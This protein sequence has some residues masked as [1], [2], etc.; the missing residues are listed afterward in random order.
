VPLIELRWRCARCGHQRIASTATLV[1]QDVVAT[2]VRTSR[3]PCR[4][5]IG[6]MHSA[7]ATSPRFPAGP[8][9]GEAASCAR[10]APRPKNAFYPPGPGLGASGVDARQ[11]SERPAKNF[12]GAITVGV[13]G[14]RAFAELIR[15]HTRRFVSLQSGGLLRGLVLHGSRSAHRIWAAGRLALSLACTATRGL[16]GR[17]AR[18]LD[19]QGGSNLKE[20]A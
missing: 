18:L 6:A 10:S 20:A 2:P 13:P 14:W 17:R 8:A 11:Y 15:Q 9:W 16:G 5:R 7:G 3:Q 12:F 4:V 19:H 1:V